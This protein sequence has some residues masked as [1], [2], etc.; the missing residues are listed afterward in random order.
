MASSRV[1]SRARPKVGANR[2]FLASLKA[3]NGTVLRAHQ[4]GETSLGW[5]VR[6]KGP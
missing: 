3:S 4:A 6:S 2:V 5:K 1:R